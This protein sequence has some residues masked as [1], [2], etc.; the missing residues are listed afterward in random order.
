VKAVSIIRVGLAETKSFAE[1]WDAIFGKGPKKAAPK[2][3]AK[4]TGAAKAPRA[5]KKKTAKKS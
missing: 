4:A 1:G 3:K 5:K 2:A